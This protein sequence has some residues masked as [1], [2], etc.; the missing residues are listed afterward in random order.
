MHRLASGAHR[1]LVVAGALLVDSSQDS[2]V[3]ARQREVEMQVPSA[4]RARSR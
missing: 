2:K 4:G 3:D 1:N